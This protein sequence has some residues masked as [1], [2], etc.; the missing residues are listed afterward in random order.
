MV[1]APDPG[2]PLRVVG[3]CEMFAPI[4]SGGFG[5]VHLGRQ[6]GAGGFSRIV[7]IKRLHGT[8]LDDSEVVAMFLDEA[9]VVA[10]IRHPNVLQTLDLVEE[11]GELFIVMEYL[12][13]VTLNLL[14][15][16][17]KKQRRRLP[18]GVTSAIMQGALAGLHAAHEATNERGEPLELIHRDVS[19]DNI[20]VGIDGYARLVD[21]GIARAV[22][23]L[24]STQRGDV[25]GKLNYMT[26]EQ[27][28]GEP[29]SRRSDVFSAAVVLWQMLTG[30][31]LFRGEHAGELAY[32]VCHAEIPPP[33]SI[34]PSVPPALER[35]VMRG[36][37]RA[38]EDRWSSAL[39][40][41]EALAAASEDVATPKE[42]GEIMVA[43][44]PAFL[45][46]RARQVK[47]VENA[48][49]DV[50]PVSALSGRF[51]A[52]TTPS[53]ETTGAD[54]GDDT[55]NPST[56][57][58]SSL[59]TPTVRPGA[60]RLTLAAVAMVGLG[61]I[62]AFAMLRGDAAPEAANAVDE[63][64]EA[65]GPAPPHGAAGT[66]APSGAAETGPSASP[67]ASATA[68]ASASAASEP[69]TAKPKPA[70]AKPKP[71]AAKPKPAKVPRFRP[72]SK[73]KPSSVYSRE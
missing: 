2:R 72:K 11:E 26:P 27:V 58:T 33:S 60:R 41:A 4:A 28:M 15:K 29:L 43:S 20:M 5:S 17:V 35:V 45:S 48:P 44:C 34:V 59:Q 57:I 49:R 31:R 6:I 52:V 25:K 32:R 66:A 9:R 14:L 55:S 38:P 7:A 1:D 30:K 68:S 16:N 19:P 67:P 61:A 53:T 10:R 3:R 24:H 63:P 51:R 47:S 13:G 70:A 40:M 62:L 64:E 71:A 12:E 21:F 23:Q 73:P 8:L 22:G 50:T 37:E 18:A 65:A 54:H 56:R 42:V 36:L 46:K 69:S 39:T